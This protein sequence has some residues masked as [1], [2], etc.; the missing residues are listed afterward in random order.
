MGSRDPRIDAYI[1]KS[2]PFAHPILAHLREI[3]HAG[4][5][6]VEETVKWSAPHFVHQGMLCAMAAFKSHCAF[7]LWNGSLVVGERAGGAMGQFGRIESV[8]DLPARKTMIAYVKRAAQLNSAGVKSTERSRPKTPKPALAMPA[9]LQS[10]LGANDEA[11]ARFAAMSP[12][13][14]REYIEWIVEAKRD[15]TRQRRVA[16]ALDW[17]AQGK[18]RN[19]KYEAK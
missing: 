10:A 3:V 11:A 16:Q 6:T 9:D 2:Q 13:H 5:P 8:K 17:I 19:W 18:S 1:E 15:A 14:R 7:S 4:C 12:S